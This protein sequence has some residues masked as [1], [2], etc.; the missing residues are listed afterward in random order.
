VKGPAPGLGLRLLAALLRACARMRLRGRTRLTL[1]LARHLESL[2][3]VPIRVADWPPIY[4]DMRSLAAHSWL[5]GTPFAS[6]PLEPSEQA[7]MRRLVRAGDVVLDVGA[8]LGVHTVLLAQLVGPQGRV[9]A[10]EPNAE[11][12]PGLQRTLA[13]LPNVTLYPC[14]LSDQ[15][16]QAVLFVPADHSMAGLADWTRQPTRPIPCATRRL[17]DLL[18][19]DGVRPPDFVKCDAEGAER[20]VFEGARR[21]LDRSDA[22]IILFEANA[23]NAA[24]FGR[25]RAD[26]AE[27]LAGRAAGYRFLAIH[28]GGHLRAVRPSDLEG[29]SVLA[30]PEA[31]SELCPELGPPPGR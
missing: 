21:T 9:L 5:L 20:L 25:T 23:N 13:A 31:R 29:H 22:P 3:G 2:Q 16:S 30:V 6:C 7:V 4:M 1:L 28:E 26:A 19:A 14:A 12:F 18:A 24:G 8:N 11:L 27:F 15:D 10:F 17:D